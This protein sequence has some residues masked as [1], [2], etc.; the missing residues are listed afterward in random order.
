[1][2]KQHTISCEQFLGRANQIGQ[3]FFSTRTCANILLA[4]LLSAFQI[5]LASGGSTSGGSP[6]PPP[7]PSVVVTVSPPS[8]TLSL[9]Q[10]QQFTATVTGT[11]NTNVTW[12]VNG[13][14]GGSP[15]S[16]T[17]SS[18]GMYAAP[19]I[20]PSPPNVAVTAIDP[21]DNFDDVKS[22]GGAL[23]SVFA[24]SAQVHERIAEIESC[25]RAGIIEVSEKSRDSKREW[26]GEDVTPSK[27]TS[28]V[29]GRSLFSD[30]DT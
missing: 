10:T 3:C 25:L 24:E 15:S 28:V 13:I 6:P 17:I 23:N 11:S 16:G 9:G 4:A 5:L 7:P 8:M 20:L 30:V 21:E 18:T 12:Q 26:I 27:I 1:M 2:A 19:P 29:G 14:A 22:L